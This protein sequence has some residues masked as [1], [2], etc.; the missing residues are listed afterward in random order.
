VDEWT[1]RGDESSKSEEKKDCLSQISCERSILAVAGKDTS[2][3]ELALLPAVLGSRKYSPRLEVFNSLAA[4][5]KDA[6]E[7]RE[8]GQY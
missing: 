8:H 6:P 2:A 5:S 4:E 7:V 1:N 3:G